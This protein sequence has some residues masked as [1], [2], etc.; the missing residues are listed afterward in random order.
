MSWFDHYLGFVRKVKLYSGDCFEVKEY[1]NP[2][3]CCAT[4]NPYWL[5]QH[6]MASDSTN[7]SCNANLP[8]TLKL[9]NFVL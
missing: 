7:Q 9:H 5:S 8:E 4:L 1:I 2:K 3:S 6:C